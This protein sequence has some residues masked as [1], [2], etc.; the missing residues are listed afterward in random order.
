MYAVLASHN[1]KTY[2]HAVNSVSHSWAKHNT[3]TKQAYF[4]SMLQ[5]GHNVYIKDLQGNL[6]PRVSLDQTKIGPGSTNVLK[7]FFGRV[8]D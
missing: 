3:Q 5:T 1:N 6:K 4:Y 8:G 2:L 7:N